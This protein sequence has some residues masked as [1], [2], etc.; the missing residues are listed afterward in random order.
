M[1][2]LKSCKNNGIACSFRERKLKR[3]SFDGLLQWKNEQK[4]LK[5]C[6]TQAV[7]IVQ[8]IILRAHFQHW[9]ALYR[10]SRMLS[11]SCDRM[12]SIKKDNLLKKS[13]KKW[14]KAKEKC[15]LHR[16]YQ[17]NLALDATRKWRRYATNRIEQRRIKEERHVMVDQFKD[18]WLTKR[19]FCVW[20][21]QYKVKLMRS[22]SRANL[23]KKHWNMWT[24]KTSM[25]VC[26]RGMNEVRVLQTFWN[27]WRMEFVKRKAVETSLNTVD[28]DL[29]K[30]VFRSWRYFT[31]GRRTECFHS[32]AESLLARTPKK[33]SK[34][35]VLRKIS[36]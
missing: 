8:N 18:K 20:Q 33:K 25:A 31:S 14:F 24:V 3:E 23:L 16:M 35:P 12:I 22:Q 10:K 5:S 29:M 19:V 13:W 26:A 1:V 6:Y 15:D 17:R 32:D 27:A 7:H 34:I 11:V 9:K 21:R 4:R 30:K 36:H 2:W 28:K